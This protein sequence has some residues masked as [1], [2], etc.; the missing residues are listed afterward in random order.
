M[1]GEI[2]SSFPYLSMSRLPA[3]LSFIAWFAL[4]LITALGIADAVLAPAPVS[5][6][7]DFVDTILASRAV[8]A[9]TRIA[10]VFAAIFVVLSVVALIARRQ[11]L[12]RVGPVEVSGEVAVL[13]AEKSRLEK[14]LQR[15]NE[16]IAKFEAAAADTQ[17]VIDRRGE[18]D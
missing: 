8:V 5:S 16:M 3:V 7:P 15:A 14:E 4:C 10:I 9:A 18:D 11:W 12:T 1:G 2:G 17:Q 13:A 6:Q